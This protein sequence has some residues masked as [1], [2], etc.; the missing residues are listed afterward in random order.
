V[1]ASLSRVESTEIGLAYDDVWKELDEEILTEGLKTI[2]P[3]GY[4]IKYPLKLETVTF[5]SDVD[6]SLECNSKDGIEVK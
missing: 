2:P 5:N 6:S 4:I 3:Y 1:P